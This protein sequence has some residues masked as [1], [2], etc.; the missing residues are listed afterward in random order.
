MKRSITWAGGAVAGVAALA[1]AVPQIAGAEESPAPGA[2]GSSSETSP[3]GDG[4]A[5]GRPTRDQMQEELAGRL[6]DELGLDQEEVAAA[7]ETVHEELRAEHEAE[8]TER[9]S[10]RLDAAVKAGRLTQEQADAILE[11]ARDGDLGGLGP[12]RHGPGRPGPGGPMGGDL[13]APDG[14]G[15]GSGSGADGTPSAYSLS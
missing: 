1:L 5:D 11:A 13:G 2:G 14:T 15:P 9:L 3:D 12:G 10:A 8:R 6:A 4:P 7:L